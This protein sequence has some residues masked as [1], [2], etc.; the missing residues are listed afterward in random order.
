MGD[1]ARSLHRE[2]EIIG[3]FLVPSLEAARPLERVKGAIDLNGV[4]RVAG[5]LQLALLRM[6]R[7]IKNTAPAFVVPAGDANP[8]IPVSSA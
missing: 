3:R 2:N 8:E 1:K 6:F 7:R 4:E 5:K